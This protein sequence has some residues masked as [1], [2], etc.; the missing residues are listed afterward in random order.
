MRELSGIGVSPGVAMGP[1]VRVAPP[2]TAI[3]DH[4]APE[5]ADSAI[6]SV[7]AAFDRVADGLDERT[8]RATGNAVKVLQATA[9]MSRDPGLRDAV[10]VKIR[11]GYGP[12]RAVE[13]AI[14][15][16]CAMFESLGGY[17]AQRV[18][19]LHDV[20]NRTIARLRG[21]PEPGVPFLREPSVL[22]AEDLSP[23]ETALLDPALCRGIVTWA[24]GPTSHT[25]I[26]ASQLGIPAIVQVSGMD[27]VEEG[28]MVAFDGGVGEVLVDPDQEALDQLAARAKRRETALGSGT[29]AG[30]TKDGHPVALLANIGTA[31]DAQAASTADVEGVGLFRTEFLFMGRSEPPSIEEQV[32]AYR[33]VFDAF[34][35]RRVVVR[36]LDAGSDKPLDFVHLGDEENPA[37]GK[38]GIRLNRV[39]ESLMSQ[40]IE[41]LSVAA[42]GSSA[43]VRVMAPMVAVVDEAEW[44]AGLVHGA[45]ITSAGVMVEVPS[46][47]LRAKDITEVV[48]FVSIGTNDL[49]QY[50]MAADRLEGPLADLLSP[51]QPAVLDL[52]HATCEG[53]E[54]NGAPVGVCGEAAGDPLLAL[55][56]VGLGVSSLSMA[57]TKVPAV[58][59]ALALHDFA[60]CQK[61]A[62]AALA[63]KTAAL[64][65]ASVIEQAHPSMVDII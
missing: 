51:W 8:A 34:S 56:L 46:A 55:V 38:R 47:A 49:S 23:S 24:G 36:T 19:D 35:G 63:A 32:E 37:L 39:A 10:G 6:A 9:M 59:A 2:P 7:I 4:S 54:I 42:E 1:V 16:F 17:M 27:S 44:F 65:R 40:Q 30:A 15:D 45:G 52:I 60:A 33:A 18:T 12:T 57:P 62:A 64:A 61:I 22:S 58:R 53:A 3:A 29:G 20:R 43:D 21:L 5:D 25:A 14:G 28:T 41:A 26:L 50:T 48:D 13:A 11:E 31:A